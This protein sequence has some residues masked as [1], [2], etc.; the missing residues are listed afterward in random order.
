MSGIGRGRRVAS[1]RTLGSW[2][3]QHADVERLSEHDPRDGRRASHITPA[4]WVYLSMMRGPFGVPMHVPNDARR[5]PAE[6]SVSK[7]WRPSIGRG[8]PSQVDD[9]SRGSW[10]DTRRTGC[11]ARVAA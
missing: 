2:S 11:L 8:V 3:E 9:V 10:R 5:D 7:P 1:V 6:R 4:H